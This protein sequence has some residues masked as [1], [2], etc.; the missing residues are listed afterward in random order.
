MWKWWSLL[1]DQVNKLNSWLVLQFFFAAEQVINWLRRRRYIIP[2]IFYSYNATLNIDPQGRPQS[3]PVVI[4]IFTQSVRPSIHT[5]ICPSVLPSVRLSVSKLQNQ[6][7]IT[8]GRDCGLAEWIIDDS[9]L[10]SFISSVLLIPNA[11]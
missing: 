5:S 4:T 10:V 9:C 11:R 1:F 3:R 8:A 2:N 7:T 6:A